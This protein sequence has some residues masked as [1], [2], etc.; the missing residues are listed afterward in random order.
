MRFSTSWEEIGYKK[1]RAEG[2]AEGKAEGQSEGLRRGLELTLKSR[3]GASAEP[4]LERLAELDLAG[5]EKLYKQL[6]RNSDLSEITA[7][8][9]E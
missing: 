6:A 4:V 5:L 1:G 8:Q 9:P 7:P 2:K 3:F